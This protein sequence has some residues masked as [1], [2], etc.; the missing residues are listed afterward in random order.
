MVIGGAITPWR[1]SYLVLALCRSHP[2]VTAVARKIPRSLCQK[3]RWQITPK[4]AYTFDPTKSKWA[5]YAAVQA[6]CGNLSGIE[7]TRKSSWEQSVT[8]VSAR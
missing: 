2:R 5:D 1:V 4:P 7:L 8:V 3:C 6:E